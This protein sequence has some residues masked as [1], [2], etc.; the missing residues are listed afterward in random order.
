MD[1]KTRTRPFYPYLPFDHN[2]PKEELLLPEARIRRE[3]GRALGSLSD[4]P[5]GCA[6]GAS[7]VPGERGG[8][9]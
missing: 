8:L 9:R 6:P 1:S 4:A 2:H 5:P 3:E 7:G